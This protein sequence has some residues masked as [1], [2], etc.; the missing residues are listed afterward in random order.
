VSYSRKTETPAIPLHP[1]RPAE[2]SQFI[3][4]L[5]LHQRRWLEDS[6]FEA[7]RGQSCPVPGENGALE[8]VVFGQAQSGWLSQLARLPSVLPQATY[9]LKSGWNADQ[10]ALASLGWGLACYRFDRYLSRPG[11]RPVLELDEDIA[12]RVEALFEATTLVRDLVNTPTEDLGPEQLADAVVTQADRFEADSHVVTGED[13]LTENFPAIHIVGRAADREPRLVSLTWG[14]DD[15]PLVALVGK[16]VCFDTG[17]LNLKPTNG[18]GLMK[19]D[20]G[21]AAH[22]LAL[23]Q[24]VMRHKLPVRLVVLIPAVENAVSGNAYRPGDVIHTRKGLSVEI[25]NTDAE[26]R[27]VLADALTLACEHTPDLVIDFAT[28]TGAARVA[29]GADLPPLFSNRPAIAAAIQQAGVEVEDGLWTMPL[30]RPYLEQIKSDIAD[31][32]NSSKS[33]YGGC[34]TAALFLEKFVEDHVPWVHIDTFAWNQ[35][36]RPGRP[37]GGEALGLRAVFAYLQQRYSGS[38]PG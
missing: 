23:A 22:A 3:T 20:M 10:R 30:Y 19:K 38:A 12:E 24:L 18:M 32:N 5:P 29:L 2:L 4:R 26:G 7:K 15:A 13:L 25:G 31:L 17:G 14:A 35:S 16:G 6:G 11:N 27:I 33:A 36:N 8:F 21:G 37:R 34:I 28:L 9:Q 1:V